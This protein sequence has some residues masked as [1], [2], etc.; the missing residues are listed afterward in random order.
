MESGR[1]R[2]RTA[3]LDRIDSTKGYVEGNVQWIH[4]RLNIMKGKSTDVTFIKDCERVVRY[5]LL[6]AINSPLA[7]DLPPAVQGTL[8]ADGWFTV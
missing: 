3:S 8:D 6:K 1:T 5:A 2:T 4:K 7:D